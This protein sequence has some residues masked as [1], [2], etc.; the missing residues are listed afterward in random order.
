MAFQ[1]PLVGGIALRKPA[2]RSPNFVAGSTGWTINID[3]S[4]EF[5]NLTLRGTFFGTDYIINASGAF[6]YSGTPALGNLTESIAPAAGTDS[7]GN[8]YVAGVASYA[9]G[10]L[11]SQLLNA[12]VVLQDQ[13]GRQV[14]LN[15]SQAAGTGMLITPAG[16]PGTYFA[17]SLLA[18]VELGPNG[19]PYA[20]LQ[21]PADQ[22]H[23]LVSTLQLLGSD[24]LNTTTAAILT[25]ALIN[26]NGAVSSPGVASFGGIRTPLV[27]FKTSDQ[28]ATNTTVLANDTQLFIPVEANA[29]YK[30]SGF[31]EFTGP[32]TAQGTGDLKTDMTLPA[33]STFRWAH[34]G[35]ISGSANAM[36]SV[37]MANGTQRALGTFGIGTDISAVVSGYLITGVNAGNMQL[38]FAQN[39]ANAIATTMRAGSWLELIRTA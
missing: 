22:V 2:V 31:L 37:A 20:L 29:T 10:G 13:N 35:A 3:G 33:G 16:S 12:Q 38:Q 6:F 25:A 1:D 26:L 28:L 39:V 24:G 9:A 30:L 19:R 17:G 32:T 11:L 14:V 5:N 15:A 23:N 4:A 36:D 8:A 34:L 21:S 18:N 27:A 7:F